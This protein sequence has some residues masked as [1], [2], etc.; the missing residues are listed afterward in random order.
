M[1]YLN[2][3]RIISELIYQKD[4]KLC[5]ILLLET[6]YFIDFRGFHL[7]W[8]HLTTLAHLLSLLWYALSSF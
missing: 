6:L 4:L 3:I 8:L 1:I 2:N 7:S 5:I